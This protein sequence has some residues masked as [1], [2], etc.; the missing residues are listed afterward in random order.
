MRVGLCQSLGDP[1]D[2]LSFALP[3]LLRP[4]TSN[5]RKN[6]ISLPQCPLPMLSLPLHL[7]RSSLPTP[8]RPA[9]SAHPLYICVYTFAHTVALPASAAVS[10]GLKAPYPREDQYQP[11]V[12]VPILCSTTRTLPHPPP[13]PPPPPITLP[14]RLSCYCH[15]CCC[16]PINPHRRLSLP[17][18]T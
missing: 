18:Y 16:V 8:I 10:P 12:I 7:P 13:P 14:N 15:C 6:F 1:A 11:V 9:L 17:A 2:S 3:R 5:L 4:S